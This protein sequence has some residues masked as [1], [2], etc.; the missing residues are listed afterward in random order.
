MLVS[1]VA[2]DS[3]WT[4]LEL[5]HK[6]R[7][8]PILKCLQ[9]AWTHSCIDHCYS[10]KWCK[11]VKFKN[12]WPPTF[13]GCLSIFIMMSCKTLLP[14][15]ELQNF[16]F[17]LSRLLKKGTRREGLHCSLYWLLVKKDVPPSLQ[18]DN[19]DCHPLWWLMRLHFPQKLLK[20]IDQAS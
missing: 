16:E 18:L 20:L 15:F 4:P 14:K 17:W 11:L 19:L 8:I 7:T 10:M 1:N 2:N 12:S 13:I 6:S 9:D 3:S 5:H